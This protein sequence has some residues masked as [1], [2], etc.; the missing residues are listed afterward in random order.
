MK[1]EPQKR[2]PADEFLDE[3][4]NPKW[5]FLVMEGEVEGH[6]NCQGPDCNCVKQLG[7]R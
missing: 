4:F 1:P 5:Y 7:E 2:E 3:I 6:E